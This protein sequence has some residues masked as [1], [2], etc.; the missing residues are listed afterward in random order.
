MGSKNFKKLQKTSTSVVNAAIRLNIDVNKLNKPV[1]KNHAPSKT[2]V[3][4]LQEFN[5]R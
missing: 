3:A 5:C 1:E 2:T 4:L